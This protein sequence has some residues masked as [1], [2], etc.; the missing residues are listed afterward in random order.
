MKFD[1]HGL[2]FN[3]ESKNKNFMNYLKFRLEKYISNKTRDGVS[4]EII[5]DRPKINLKNFDRISSTLYSREKFYIIKYS[6]LLIHYELRKKCVLVKAYFFPNRKKHL[7]RMIMKS[8]KRTY[9]DYYEFFII[10]KVI[11][12]TFFSLLEKEGKNILHASTVKGK[13]GSTLFF[14]LGGLGKTTLALDLVLSKK[15][16]LQGDNFVIVDRKNVFSYLEPSRIT[17]YTRKKLNL[18]NSI[19]EKNINTFGKENFYFKENLLFNGKSKIK[20]IVFP[21]LSEKVSL[22]KVNPEIA[23]KRIESSM[24]ILRE[25]PEFTEINSIFPKKKFE[26]N[27]NIKFYEIS[28]KKLEDARSILKKIL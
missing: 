4:F 15:L 19:V 26:I 11:Q 7:A 27:K 17:K 1:I 8:K 16:K 12:N 13:N 22:K 28:Y 21:K 23:K 6:N 24:K 2:G 10:R 18:A 20:N 3:V 25:T 5:F 14:G 9:S